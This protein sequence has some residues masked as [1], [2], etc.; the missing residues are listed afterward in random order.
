[1]EQ[2]DTMTP[3]DTPVEQS[4][5]STETPQYQSELKAFNTYV[6]SNQVQVPSNF[7]TAGDWF[8]SL[9]NAQSEYTKARQELAQLKK[10]PV[11]PVVE[12]TVE[13]AA[14]EQTEVDPV[15]QIQEEL[16]IPKQEPPKE[17]PQQT[18]QADL[19]QEEW[20]K[21]SVEVATTGELSQESRLAIKQKTKLP[22]FV[23]D[24]FM[25]GQKARLNA[26]YTEAAKVIGGKDN[27]ARVFN[28]ASKNLSQEQ[29]AEINATLASPSW[30]VALLGLKAKYD[31]ATANKP[32]S[33]EPVTKVGEKVSV[34]KAQAATGPY[35]SKAEFYKDRSNPLFKADSRFRQTVEARM[36][37]TDF[38]K[39]T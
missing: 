11:A 4:Q 24:E 8:K 18:A 21:Y 28:W 38:N 10:Q 17:Q 3:Q 16:R 29:Q 31:S 35:L 23:I 33:K 13:D 30:E 6:E 20:K 37:K 19:T 12:E 5:V 27:L 32:T 22:D 2:N 14:L 15:P 1:M 7:K 25:Q 26:A 39:L 34:A 9:K 36:M